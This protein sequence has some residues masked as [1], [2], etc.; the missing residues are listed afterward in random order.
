MKRL[1]AILALMCLLLPITS[2]AM[3]RPL[4]Y[5]TEAASFQSTSLQPQ[6]DYVP[7]PIDSDCG[8]AGQKCRNDPVDF[9]DPLGLAL[10]PEEQEIKDIGIN[11]DAR[12]AGG[13]QIGPVRSARAAEQ[14]GDLGKET[15]LGVVVAVVPTE[16]PVGWVLEEVGGKLKW[17]GRGIAGLFKSKATGE[18]R[19]GVSLGRDTVVWERADVT[20]LSE[21][22]TAKRGFGDPTT[23]PWLTDTR[24]AIVSHIEQFRQGGSYIVDDATYQRFITGKAFVGRSGEGVF[25]TTRAAMDRLVA[26][27]GGDL[28]VINKRLSA[29]FKGKLYR[30]DIQDPLL[31]NARLPTGL[32]QGA[33]KS[34]KWG[35]YTKGGMPEV[36]VDPVPAGAF[37]ATPLN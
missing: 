13:V 19:A 14:I 10:S 18:V 2:S 3:V 1:L 33:N 37:T 35:G 16:R 26:E 23:S 4:P 36:I 6:L 31:H 32:E 9:S 17:I 12:T 28:S 20:A 8:F 22:K 27:A 5:A 24:T 7:I 34:F 21:G 15:V 29:N 30:V 25:I 11:L